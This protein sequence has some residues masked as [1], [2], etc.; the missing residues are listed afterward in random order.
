MSGEIL[1]KK[2]YVGLDES[3]S[4]LAEAT[5]FLMASGTDT[6]I[7]NGGSPTA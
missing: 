5:A 1:P 4:F 2:K 3:A 6:D 7:H